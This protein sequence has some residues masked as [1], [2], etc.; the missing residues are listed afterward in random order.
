MISTQLMP[1]EDGERW[2]LCQPARGFNLTH[3]TGSV[4]LPSPEHRFGRAVR[5]AREARGWSQ[6]TLNLQLANN[7]LHVGGQSGVARIERAERP[8]RLNE[9]T[10]IAKFLGIDMNTIYEPNEQ[11]SD[12]DAQA[13]FDEMDQLGAALRENNRR[14]QE[15]RLA[16]GELQAEQQHLQTRIEALGFALSKAGLIH[17]TMREELART[18]ALKRRLNQANPAQEESSDG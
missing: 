15:L 4:E 13:A 18:A 16:Q 11:L 9:A 17:P 2:L 8:T 1:R 14:W 12:E 7:G 3:V 10:R 5:L 6:E